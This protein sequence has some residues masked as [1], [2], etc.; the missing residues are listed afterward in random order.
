M[1]QQ[2]DRIGHRH[3]K[4]KSTLFKP[5]TFDIILM[6]ADGEFVKGTRGSQFMYSLVMQETTLKK[7]KYVCL[8]EPQWN[9]YADNQELYRDVVIDI[10]SPTPARLEN[11]EYNEGLEVFAKAVQHHAAT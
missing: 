6:T 1:L 7:G 11:I 5:S 2:G 3:D 8:V 10:Y 4:D 9:E